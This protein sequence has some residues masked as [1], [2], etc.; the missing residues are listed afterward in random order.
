MSPARRR[1]GHIVGAEVAEVE[2][3]I[4][5]YRTVIDGNVALGAPATHNFTFSVLRNLD[6]PPSETVVGFTAEYRLDAGDP[7]TVEKLI[8]IVRRK[9]EGD[10]DFTLIAAGS[11]K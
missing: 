5:R 1:C 2:D 8:P 9:E 3:R 6:E 11:A 7:V 10:S 4:V